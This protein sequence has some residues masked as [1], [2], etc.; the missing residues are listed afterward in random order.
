MK[1]HYVKS[2]VVA[3]IGYDPQTLV[4][5]VRFH[6]RDIYRYFDVQ[7]EEYEALIKAESFGEHFNRIFKSKNH[8]F[9][10]IEEL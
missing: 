10:K 2:S 6:N 3:T 4:L 5:E 8:G 7:P 1:R 9:K